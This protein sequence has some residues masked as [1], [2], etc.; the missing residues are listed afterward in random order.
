M[1]KL[2]A[3]TI[4]VTGFFVAAGAA[5]SANAAEECG[6]ISIA[7]MNWASAG[8][9]AYVDKFIMENG[10]DCFQLFQRHVSLPLERRHERLFMGFAKHRAPRKSQ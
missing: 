4:L 5:S 8:V 7:E 9:A 2:L 1:K 10:Y 6:S 3:S